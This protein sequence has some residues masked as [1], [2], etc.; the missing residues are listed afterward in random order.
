MKKIVAE[1]TKNTGQHDAKKVPSF[2]GGKWGATTSVVAPGDTNPSDATVHTLVWSGERLA[3][4]A[5]QQHVITGAATE[6]VVGVSAHSPKYRLG[7][8]TPQNFGLHGRQSLDSV[9]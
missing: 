3:W 5:L 8:S 6:D 1:F 2:L 7:F 4:T 9:Y